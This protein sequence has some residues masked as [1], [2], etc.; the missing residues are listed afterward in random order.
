MSGIEIVGLLLGAIPLVISALEHYEDALDPAIAFIK[1]GRELSVA[2]QSLWYPVEPRP[3]FARTLTRSSRGRF[4]NTSYTQSIQ[5]LLRPITSDQELVDMMNDSDNVLWKSDDM[6]VA[7]RDRLGDAYVAYM[8]TIAE[9]QK[10]T[11]SLAEKLNIDGAQQISQ[12]GLEVILRSNPTSRKDGILGFQFSK[13]V[14]F[15]MK[16]QKVKRLLEELE[17]CNRRLDTYA[18]KAEKLE[19]PYKAA[20]QSKFALP[21]YM[22]EENTARLYD[23]LSRTWCSNHSSHHAGLLLEQRLVKKRNRKTGRERDPAEKCDINCFRIS[24]LQSPS[25]RRWLEVEFRLTE[26]S[27]QEPH[28]SSVVQIMVPVEPPVTS[29]PALYQEPAQ[30]Q[31][32]TNLCSVLKQ[33]IHPW[34][35][36]CLE[37]NGLL[38]GAYPAQPQGLAHI[39]DAVSLEELLFKGHA[40]LSKEDAYSLSITLSSSL[41]QLGHTPWLRQSWGKSDIIF[42]RGK[43]G[44][45]LSVDVKHPYITREHK[46]NS[47]KPVRQNESPGSDCS[48]LL[49]LAVLLIE[50]NSGEPIENLRTPEDLGPDRQ[51]NELSNLQAGR[52]WILEQKSKGNLTAAFYSAILHCL[53]G[54]VDPTASLRNP[55]FRRSVEEQVLAPLEEELNFLFGSAAA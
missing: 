36:F 22:V 51:I 23:V 25:T 32:V 18:N 47:I 10:I 49:A 11:Q 55:E 27:S 37:S 30:L 48:K 2:T 19:S 7:L 6:A 53:K 52:R 43:D 54:F 4:Q 26:E 24:L 15:T 8:E 39:E 31:V 14:K 1:W 46:P 35:G 40:S 33:P 42:L 17:M 34:L 21:L 12:Q 29:S 16:R 13:R 3:V 5:L 28:V 38:R 41:I 44:T 50:I 45:A 9:I 20:K